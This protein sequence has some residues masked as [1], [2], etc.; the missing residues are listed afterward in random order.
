MVDYDHGLE[1]ETYICYMC[2][3][4]SV[5]GQC[6]QRIF[7]IRKAPLKWFRHLIR[8]KARYALIEDGLR[9]TM[10]EDIVYQ[11]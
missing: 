3:R 7:E 6:A 10:T 2:L 4:G 11:S 1:R 9:S 5:G 8:E